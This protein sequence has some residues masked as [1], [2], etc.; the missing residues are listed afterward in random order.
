MRKLW[1]ILRKEFILL[2]RDIP[3]LIILF[4]IGG[5]AGGAG[6]AYVGRKVSHSRTGAI[7]GA[8]AGGAGGA[9]VGKIIAEP[10]GGNRRDQ[11]RHGRH[12][13]HRH[14][15][16]DNRDSYDNRDNYRYREHDR[17]ED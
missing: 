3:G 15:H 13:N 5:A 4:M 11:Y 2:F 7:V 8:G 1:Y 12:R 10:E 17:H 6:G 16:Y 14:E 9:V